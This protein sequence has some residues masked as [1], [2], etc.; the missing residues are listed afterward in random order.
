MVF[1]VGQN[2]RLEGDCGLHRHSVWR[3]TCW[4]TPR[5]PLLPSILMGRVNPPSFPSPVEPATWLLPYPEVQN[6]RHSVRSVPSPGTRNV[7]R[8]QNPDPKEGALMVRFQGSA[9]GGVR[10]GSSVRTVPE[11][12]LRQ[13]VE[14]SPWLVLA[15]L[16]WGARLCPGAHEARA[17]RLGGL[18]L[19][20]PQLAAL[21][22]F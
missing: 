13:S 20:H 17:S 15:K 8:D 16:R 12:S 4:V 7:N 14:H 22:S 11:S 5:P 10:M 21:G 2:C 9:V 19:L 18:T 1:G 3:C 6:P